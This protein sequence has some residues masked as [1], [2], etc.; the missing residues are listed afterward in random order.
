M[1]NLVWK[2]ESAWDKYSNCPGQILYFRKKENAERLLRRWLKTEIEIWKRAGFSPCWIHSCETW[3]EVLEYL[4]SHGGHPN[5]AWIDTI[6][7]EDEEE[8]VSHE[9]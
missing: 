8:G 9:N 6:K 4:M 1:S 3:E 7:F 5:V 2:V